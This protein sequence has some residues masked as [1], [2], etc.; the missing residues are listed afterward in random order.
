MPKKPFDSGLYEADDN[1][2]FD[3]IDW[4]ETNEYTAWVNPDQYGI[5]VLAEKD[6]LDYGFEVEVKHNWKGEDFPFSSVHFSARKKKFIA[7]NHFFT[8]LNHERSLILVVDGPTL[9]RSSVL[10]KETKYTTDEQFISVPVK[11]CGIFR[12]N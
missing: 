9:F 2:K 5:D 12:L 11:S 6:L 3:V 4:L 1:A 8:M 10:S 7:P